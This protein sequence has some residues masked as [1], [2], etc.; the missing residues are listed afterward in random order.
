L[1]G[2]FVVLR[3]SDQEFIFGDGFLHN[4]SSL[5]HPM[6]A[7]CLIPITPEIAVFY[8]RPR[9]YR[10]FPK[11]LVLNLTQEEVAVV[12]LT[13]Q[14]YS[15]RYLFFRSIYPVIDEVFRQGLRLEFQY[16]EHP[17]IE[18]LQHAA[19]QTYFGADNDFCLQSA[20][21]ALQR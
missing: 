12:N 4:F 21:E 6:H 3:A 16:H 1:G 11:L 15:L 17:L 19:S 5:D 7:R 18:G 8:T 2:K 13:V 20:G 14:I 10:T 9:A